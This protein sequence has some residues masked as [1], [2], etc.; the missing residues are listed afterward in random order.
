MSDVHGVAM[1][2]RPKAWAH[3]EG[4][5]L[6]NWGSI[7]SGVLSTDNPDVE[8]IMACMVEIFVK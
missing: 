3:I 6:W 7:Y 2:L 1:V 8:L 5:H 4:V